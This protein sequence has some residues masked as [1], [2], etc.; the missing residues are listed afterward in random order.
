VS[1][2]IFISVFIFLTGSLN[3][4]NIL[5]VYR[6][7]PNEHCTTK[8]KITK[9]DGSFFAENEENIR[10]E[11]CIDI[12]NGY[13]LISDEGTGGGSIFSQEVVIFLDRDSTTYVGISESWKDY[14]AVNKEVVL[15]TYE[16]E[17]NRIFHIVLTFLKYENSTFTEVTLRVLP[18]IKIIDFFS[19]S[20]FRT[21][22]KKINKI[23][24]FLEEDE[25]LLYFSLPKNGYKIRVFINADR[26]RNIDSEIFEML[27]YSEISLKWDKHLAKFIVSK[28]KKFS[29][30]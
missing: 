5:Q 16:E 28:K 24:S 4:S 9:S 7:I 27:K 17:Y 20:L 2:K 15:E 18:E 8:Y 6:A 26:I 13:L 14:I 19:D 29:E 12:K 23:M 25:S 30:M 21:L 1:L 3:K 11:S 10:V 22:E